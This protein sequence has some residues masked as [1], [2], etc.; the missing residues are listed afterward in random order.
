MEALPAEK[1]QAVNESGQPL[2]YK[3]ARAALTS[4]AVEVVTRVVAI[5]LSIATARTLEPREVGLLG[6]AVIMVGFISMVG[7]YP[8]MAAVAV[9]GRERNGKYATAAFLLRV[10]MVVLLLVL[11]KLTFP[12][13]AELLT[14]KEGGGEQLRQIVQILLLA[15]VVEM[16]GC[17]PQVILQRQLD[18]SWIAGIQL[19][20]PVVFVGLAVVL[21]VNGYG[22]MGVVWASL[23]GTAVVTVLLWLRLWR[24]TWIEWEGWPGR[25]E[26]RK[27]N[28][29]LAKLF[30]GG[31]GGYL[32]AR[33]DNLLVAGVLGPTAMSFYSMAW[34]ASRVPTGIFARAISSVLVPTLARIGDDTLRVQRAVRETLQHSYLLVTPICAVLF[35][36]A[37]SLVAVVLGAKWLPIVPGLR[38][39]CFT[40]L[41]GPML[42]ASYAVL[43][44]SGRAQLAALGTIV[45]IVL[46]V[47]TMQPFTHR[48]GIVGAAYSDM[49]SGLAQTVVFYLITKYS[50]RGIELGVFSALAVPITAAIVAGAFAWWGGGFL[51]NGL[52]RLLGEASFFF[53]A[54]PLTVAILGG[55]DRL[56]DLAVLLKGLFQRTSFASA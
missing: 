14:G 50:T 11:L 24:R 16:L 10:V 26:W 6:L 55:K 25:D 33:V 46:L 13:C 15:P 19:L 27:V 34:N 42:D 36:T 54:Y 20:H 2:R 56:S 40:V 32:G 22:P 3:T 12:I 53:L 37:P 7:C 23:T 1:E 31:F 51:S 47:L 9:P 48:W 21:L 45:R 30:T 39:M 29:N 44:S 17:Y 5:A 43:I 28:L 49:V 38:V 52:G 8:E 41:V 4:G 35:V 18:L